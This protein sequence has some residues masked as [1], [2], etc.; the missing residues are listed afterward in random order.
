VTGILV[1]SDFNAELVSRYLTSDQS[2]PL[3]SAVTAP[4]GQVFQ[5]LT[6][7]PGS[8]DMTAFIWT[9]PEGAIPEYLKVLG[10]EP[11]QLDR[12]FADV[13]VF[14]AAIRD[15]A[16]K[17]ELVLVASWTPS[18]TGRGLGMLEWTPEGQ[19]SC[20]ARMNIALADALASVQNTFV[21]DSQR[22]LDTARPARDA[23]YW[24]SAKCP[25]TESVCRAAANDVKAALRAVGGL[26]RKIVAVDLDNTLWGGIVGEDGRE[27]LRIGGHDA[28]GEA[29]VDFQRALKTLSRHGIAIAA[30]SK[31]EERVAL[32]VFDKHPE[33]VLR[34]SDLAAWRINWQNKDQNIIELAR[35]LNLGLESFVFID[36]DATERGRVRENLPGVLVPEWPRDPARFSEALRELDCFDSS[37]TTTEDRSRARMYAQQRD[38]NNSLARASSADEWLC[39]LGIRVEI[40]TVR[41]SNIKRSIQL[42]NKTNQMNLSTRRMT[43]LELIR[44]LTEQQ[45]QHRTAVT[46]TVADRF[47]DLGLTGLIT[48]QT[49]G[50]DLEIVDFILSCRAMGR[51]IE[52]LMAHLAVESARE[53]MLRSVIARLV[54][55]TRN[56]PC[57]HFWHKSGFTECEPNSFVWDASEPYPKPVFIS[58]NMSAGARS[59]LRDAE[60]SVD[61]LVTETQF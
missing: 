14:A 36:D 31:N 6:G 7:S 48:W 47:G 49:T 30:V 19:A 9:R 56:A 59:L 27:G 40:E 38:R 26:A 3:C 29:Y 50:V 8:K 60:V 61:L 45:H 55:T 52:N 21:L 11:T 37:G 24:F 4:Y 53:G 43:E 2:A 28:V 35:E 18:Q 42:V 46:L 22:W 39:S 33:M 16:A 32:D 1:I 57:R 41:K 12:L 44:W 5:A 51:Q 13:D 17:C 54:P 34:R 58:A 23:K 20:L 15:F 10:R 25:F